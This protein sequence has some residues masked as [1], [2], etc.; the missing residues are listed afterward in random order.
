MG[1]HAEDILEGLVCEWCGTWFDDVFDGKDPP[2][3]PRR[4]EQCEPTNRSRRQRRRS[5]T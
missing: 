1:E 2:G 4:C 3:H 5:P